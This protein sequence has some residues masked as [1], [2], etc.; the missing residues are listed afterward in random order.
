[1]LTVRVIQLFDELVALLM[2]IQEIAE[3]IA[4]TEDFVCFDEHVSLLIRI[5]TL[6]SRPFRSS[7]SLQN[8]RQ[9]TEPTQILQKQMLCLCQNRADESEADCFVCVFV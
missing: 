1:M 4:T 7:G 9:P 6:L 5:A 8:I 2:F 3:Q